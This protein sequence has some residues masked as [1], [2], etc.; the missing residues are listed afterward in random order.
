MKRSCHRRDT[1]NLASPRLAEG[2]KGKPGL[3][4]SC[5]GKLSL[6]KGAGDF[7]CSSK[8]CSGTA[9]E[10]KGGGGGGWSPFFESY[11]NG[12]AGHEAVCP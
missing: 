4:F 2:D 1:I 11:G 8:R 5:I 9:P 3:L 7:S 6:G 12:E 10:V